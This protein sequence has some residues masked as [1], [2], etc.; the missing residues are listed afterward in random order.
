MLTQI[1]FLLTS[2]AAILCSELD[3]GTD[4][5]TIGN[6]INDGVV[7]P[8]WNYHDAAFKSSPAQSE[9]YFYVKGLSLLG[10]EFDLQ[11]FHH[12]DEKN[13]DEHRW[14]F[15]NVTVDEKIDG[16]FKDIR[17]F[18]V[19]QQCVDRDGGTTLRMNVT[20]KAFSCEPVTF[21][22]LKVCGEPMATRDGLS[23]GLK[24]T[25]SEIVRNGIVTSL[26]DGNIKSRVY[27]VPDDVETL[28]IYAYL[29]ETFLKAF[30]K[31]PYIITDHEIMYPTISG[32]FSKSGWI[33]GDILDMTINFNC[34]SKKG[35]K[36]EVILVVEL[37][38]F[39][40][41]EIH[42]FKICGKPKESAGIWGYFYYLLIVS[43]LGAGFFVVYKL[44]SSSG[45][46]IAETVKNF[47]NAC[48][49]KSSGLLGKKEQ[50]FEMDDD[51]KHGLNVH[52]MYG[53]A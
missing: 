16:L 36:E 25:S 13:D 1:I 51:G 27:V 4:I 46:G 40:D 2:T 29:T 34:L 19:T 24:E 45:E 10:P 6:V 30:Y 31:E 37:P 52:T 28:T 39:H 44:Y 43:A 18:K 50:R 48:R 8:G 22:W 11:D 32:D 47:W 42:F 9:I 23:I 15:M 35:K 26:F 7:Q 14:I 38:Y 53:T 5:S 33:E 21:N 49:S 3:I 41:L 17:A 20:F 12:E